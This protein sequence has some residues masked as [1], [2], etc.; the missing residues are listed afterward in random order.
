M[1]ANNVQLCELFVA[2]LERHRFLWPI[3][4][5]KN[6]HISPSLPLLL[7]PLFLFCCLPSE[8]ILNVTPVTAESGVRAEIKLIRGTEND[9]AVWGSQKEGNWRTRRRKE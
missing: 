4:F 9:G 7:L 2:E 5:L 3:Y 8:S 1:S 6:I